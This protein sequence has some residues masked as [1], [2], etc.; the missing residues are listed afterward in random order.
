MPYNHLFRLSVAEEKRLKH[1]LARGKVLTSFTSEI[2]NRRIDIPQVANSSFTVH[3]CGMLCYKK[4]NDVSCM[5]PTS[6]NFALCVSA[7]AICGSREGK[8]GKETLRR[9][10]RLSAMK[11][12]I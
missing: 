2:E 1:E 4:D 12:T 8:V 3:E 6:N 11:H 10:V 7:V 9:K 5:V